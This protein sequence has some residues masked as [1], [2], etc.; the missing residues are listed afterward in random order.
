MSTQ[1]LPDWLDRRAYPFTPRAMN[2]DGGTMSYI[3]EGSGSPILLV[4]GTPTWSFLYRSIIPE[5]ARHGRVIAPD[6]IGFGLSDKPADWGYRPADH[7]RNLMMLI[8]RLGLEE[9]TLVVHDFGGPIGLSCAVER[10]EKFAR[11]VMF[12]TW[13]W[14][15]AGNRAAEMGSRLFGGALGRFLY[16]RLNFSPRVL[17]PGAFGDKSKLTPEIHRHYLAPFGSAAERVAPWRL[18]QE[19]IGSSAWYDRLW[20]RRD[21]IA[22]IPALLLWGMKD[23]TFGPAYLERWRELF[24][25]ATVETYPEAGHFVQ[26]EIGARLAGPIIEVIGNAVPART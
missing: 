18:A 3:D 9:I 26:E 22:A 19:L 21:R 15:L 16:T 14:S 7:A 4:H 8:D 5:L 10:P 1:Q 11:I 25:D 12:N 23:P 17:L 24:P 6:H 2:V 13:M 20:N